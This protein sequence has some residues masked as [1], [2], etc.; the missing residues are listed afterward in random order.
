[1]DRVVFPL[2][3]LGTGMI[4]LEGTG[5]FAQVSLRHKPQLEHAPILFAAVH[6]EGLARVLEGPVPRWKAQGGPGVSRCI[7]LPRFAQATFVGRFPSARVS[8]NDPAM[9]LTCTL[10][11]W[12]PF[13]PGDPDVSSLPLAKLDYRFENRTERSLSVT[14][15]LHSEHFLATDTPGQSVQPMASGV[16]LEQSGSGE[17][18]WDQAQL[19]LATD[20]DGAIRTDCAWFRGGWWDALTVQWQR[21]QAGL[22]THSRIHADGPASPGASLYVQIELP[23]GEARRVGFVVAWHVPHS[24]V[25]VQPFGPQGKAVL[26]PPIPEEPTTRHRPWYAA[27]FADVQAVF[28][29]WQRQ[30][31]SLEKRTLAFQSALW[32]ST[33][34]AVLLDA[35]TANLSILRSPTVLRQH[36]G[37]LW[38]WEGSRLTEG[39]CPGSCTH[40]WNYAQAIPH[41]FPSL[42]RAQREAELGLGLDLQGHQAFRLPL[43]LGAGRHSYFAAADGQLGGL[44][45]THREWRISG[46]L[47]WLRSL[48]PALRKSLDYAIETWD[49]GRKGLLTEPHHNTYDVRFWGPDGLCGTV[50]AAALGAAVVMGDAVGHDSTQDQELYL[51]AVQAL[52]TELFDGESFV[53]QVSWRD[54]RAGSPVT[55][56]V[57]EADWTPEAIALLEREGPRYQVGD[58]CLSDGVFGAWL[59]EMCG[60][61]CTLNPSMIRSHLEA[62]FH[63][64]FRP[65]LVDHCNPQRPVLAFG[66]ESGLLLCTWPHSDPPTLPFVY[67]N[68]IWTGI[69]YQVAGHMLRHGLIDQAEQIVAAARNRYDGRFRN[70]YDE[71]ECG[72]Y[73]ARALSSYGLLQA[74]TG[75][76][77][78]RVTRTLWLDPACPGDFQVFLATETGWGTV[79]L[80]NG[81]VVVEVVEGHI[82]IDRIVVGRDEQVSDSAST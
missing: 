46:D 58:G 31:L 41:L 29:Y 33:L 66:E 35:V 23:P 14:V 6:V 49:P 71:I 40:V 21:I 64:N 16:L 60:L 1:L 4:G 59:A 25:C 47:D 32:A 39:C 65:S 38:C 27:R 61:A 36:D 68:E 75:V 18:P 43:P 53:Q 73:Y 80:Q 28:A 63:H 67:A 22:P 76:R 56:D 44:L 69:E 26:G 45:T 24:D 12:S 52:E 50:Y 72:H 34:P 30:A 48:W 15:S 11:A 20:S 5:G 57:A 54:A 62:V 17:R 77:Y 19:L 42:A 51:R 7:G 3:G 79:G 70:P 82:D 55:V 78:D 2:G 10:D 74:W 8:L 13:V 81:K 9:P 37:R